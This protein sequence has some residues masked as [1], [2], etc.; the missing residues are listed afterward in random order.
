[1]RKGFRIALATAAVAAGLAFAGASPAQAQVRFRG[2]FPLPHGQISIGFGD[3]YFP[4]GSYAPSYCPVY[5]HPRYGYGFTYQSRFIP[6]RQYRSRWVVVE[7]PVVVE[8]VYTDDDYDGD[9]DDGYSRRDS[10]SDRDDWRYS[11]DDRYRDSA[12]RTRVSDPYCTH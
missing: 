3:P 8:R 2:S 7:R 5:A 9:F 10:Y 11:R 6:V 4:V 1:M 12:Y